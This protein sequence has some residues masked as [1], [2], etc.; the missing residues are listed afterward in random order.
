MIRAFQSGSKFKLHYIWPLLPKTVEN[1]RNRVIDNF[2]QFFFCQSGVRCHSIW[3]RMLDLESSSNI[4]T[5]R[6]A[7]CYYFH[8]LNF[9]PP[10]SLLDHK[11]GRG[12]N[13]LINP[14]AFEVRVPA[15]CVSLTSQFTP[16][17][18]PFH[19]LC[20]SLERKPSSWSRIM[21][22]LRSDASIGDSEERRNSQLSAWWII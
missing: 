1:W 20:F 18:L 11:R 14:I 2:R 16:S 3:I 12:P 4:E 17:V 21:L 7:F 19:H 5:L 22:S 8:I 6:T 10:M 9:W 15:E 13:S